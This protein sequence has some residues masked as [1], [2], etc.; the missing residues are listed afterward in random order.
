MT[1]I[2][3]SLIASRSSIAI[4]RKLFLLGLITCSCH[5]LAHSQ[6]S[7]SVD[8]VKTEGIGF[9]LQGGSSATTS[10]GSA[11]RP[12]ETIVITTKMSGIN[13]HQFFLTGK[14]L[15]SVNIDL[16]YSDSPTPYHIG[17]KDATIFTYKQF[18]GTVGSLVSPGNGIYE[19]V[20]LK[21]KSIQTVSAP[22]SAN[23]GASENA[24]ESVENGYQTIVCHFD[25]KNNEHVN[26][27]INGKDVLAFGDGTKDV[28]LG[29]FL[30][31]GKMNNITFTFDKG[32]YSKINLLGKF[33]GDEKGIPIYSFQPSSKALEGTFNFAFSGVK[34]K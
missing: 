20:S 14:I 25:I 22:S 21:Y 4:K 10:G 26:V 1:N 23:S 33:E 13:F 12:D 16:N 32:A 8:G 7:I 9:M 2:L 34:K 6:I 15:S 5:L 29:H 31:A 27:K 19:E 28:D 18:M 17:L 3:S 24:N 11:G 30:A